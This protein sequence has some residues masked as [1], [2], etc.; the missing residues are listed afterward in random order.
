MAGGERRSLALIFCLIREYH[1][2]YYLLG[3]SSLRVSA[4]SPGTTTFGDGCLVVPPAYP[5]AGS[6]RYP[7]ERR[8]TMLSPVCDFSSS[9]RSLETA[10]RILSRSLF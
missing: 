2:H 10:M 5:R 4:V 9:R 3:R 7:R 6:N 8:L 1:K